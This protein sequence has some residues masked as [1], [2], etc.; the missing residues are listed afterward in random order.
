MNTKQQLG[1]IK[2]LR[3][4]Y[5][6]VNRMR[7]H[8]GTKIWPTK[9]YEIWM[10]LQTLLYK[11][12]PVSL[13]EF[14]SGRST[15]YLAEYALKNKAKFASI[16]QNKNYVKKTKKGLINSMLSDEFV[17]HVPIVNRYSWF[18]T[19]KLDRI[20]NF[21]PEFILVDAPGG[22]LNK[23]SRNS[24]IGNAYIL[25]LILNAKIVIVDDTHRES[26]FEASRAFTNGRYSKISM[27]YS[28]WSNQNIITFYYLEKY[29][30]V[31]DSTIKFW[32]I[33]NRIIK[34]E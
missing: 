13:V 27:C 29:Q 1:S 16:E 8:T 15:N 14:G 11:I 31:I 26:V 34:L 17:H 18:D 23:G 28:A 24:K 30:D 3:K 5:N 2:V 32:G 6:F 12:K 7:Y 19:S 4:I 25:N 10:F 22:G 9:S 21:K 20:I 33:E